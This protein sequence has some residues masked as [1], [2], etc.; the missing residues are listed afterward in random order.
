MKEQGDNAPY[1]LDAFPSP[2]VKQDIFIS[3][4]E[5][6][7]DNKWTRF[8]DAPLGVIVIKKLGNDGTTAVNYASGE[9]VLLDVKQGRYKGVHAPAYKASKLMA[10]SSTISKFKQ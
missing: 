10:E 7:G 6:S 8:I 9:G 5:G 4:S 2:W 3:D 1:D